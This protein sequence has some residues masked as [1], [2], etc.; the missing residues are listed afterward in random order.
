MGQ[1]AKRGG[2]TY[3]FGTRTGGCDEVAR[4]GEGGGAR[5]S[6]HFQKGEV[7]DVV[8]EVCNNSFFDT[9]QEMKQRV[10]RKHG[11]PIARETLVYNGKK[12]SI[13]G[14]QLCTKA[15]QRW[16]LP[17]VMD[18]VFE[19]C[20]NKYTIEISFFDTVQEMK[21]RVERK[22]GFPIAR[23]TLGEVMDVVFE[24]C[25]NKYTIE[26]SFFDT[27]QEMK[28]RVERKHGFPIARETL[29]YNDKKTSIGCAQLCTKACQRWLLPGGI[30]RPK[31]EGDSHDFH[32]LLGNKAQSFLVINKILQQLVF[33]LI[34]A[35]NFDTVK[36]EV[37]DVVFDV[38]NN[39]YTI[40]ISFFDT[41]Q[42]MKERVERKHGFPIARET[43][44]YN[45]KKTSIGGAQLCTKACQRWL[46]PGGIG[47]PK[48]E[49][50]SHEFHYLL[51]NKAKSF[52]VIKL[53]TRLK[54]LLGEVMD[55]VF[56]VCNNKYTIEISFFDTVQE[57][58][59]RV[60]RKHG[61][62]IARETL[63]YNGKKTSIG[64]AQLCTKACQRW[65]LPGGIGRPKTEG[66]SHDFH[67]LLGNKAQSFLVIKLRTRLK[68]LLVLTELNRT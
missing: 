6:V 3:L 39:K 58:K 55:V 27:V 47:R 21:E 28:E 40:E 52:L 41:V 9:V 35:I 66:D 51:G 15:C 59:E 4:R 56:E 54:S 36:G 2:S 14:A 33:L 53:R 31:T 25:N 45:G 13:G 65:L 16:L 64:G 42:E 26:I 37:V 17:D 63:V 60:E 23:E 50:D 43:L 29:V 49:G 19:V 57:M 34:F 7:M 46:L 8:F 48:T 12:T 20:N 61:F 22:H 18:V 38:C 24:V 62:P 30:G 67:Y 44:V 5:D 10:E 1:M 32:Y 68:S 11:F